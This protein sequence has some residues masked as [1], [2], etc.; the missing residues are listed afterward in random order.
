VTYNTT[1]WDKATSVDELRA[2]KLDLCAIR[3]V[4]LWSYV[5]VSSVKRHPYPGQRTFLYGSR[6]GC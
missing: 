4:H 6:S 3:D 2:V 5:P 1:L